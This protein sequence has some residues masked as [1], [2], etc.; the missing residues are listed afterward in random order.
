MILPVLAGIF[1]SAVSSPPPAP[2]TPS[3]PPPFAGFT[4]EEKD[5]ELVVA[6]S[7]KVDVHTDREPLVT[8]GKNGRLEITERHAGTRRHL[9]MT[10]DEVTWTVDGRRRKLD[11]E[12]RAW[13]KR[14]LE[15]A[16]KPPS[17]P[18]QH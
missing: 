16:P 3:S 18:G 5:R 7:G 8:F 11:A 13:L 2:E 14:T 10:A 15:S 4:I 12:G 1:L 17:P 9:V 6:T